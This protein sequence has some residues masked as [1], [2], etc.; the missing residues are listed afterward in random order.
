MTA[1]YWPQ[2]RWPAVLRSP[3]SI[4]LYVIIV[5]TSVTQLIIGPEAAH[6]VTEHVSTNLANLLAFRWP[7]LVAS[8][9]WLEGP[10]FVPQLAVWFVL[11]VL[12]LVPAEQ[13]LGTRRWLLAFL[14]AHIGATIVTAF[15]LW[16]AVELGHQPYAAHHAIDVGLSYGFLGVLALQVYRLPFGW[17]WVA[18]GA[19]LAPLF[20]ILRIDRQFTDAGHVM[21]VLIGLSMYPIAK[22]ARDEPHAA[23]VGAAS[24]ATRPARAPDRVVSPF[25][26]D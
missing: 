15:R 24:S 19:L 18:A 26:E 22:A 7:V 23:E 3:A 20:V 12:V 5:A 16:I 6:R 8:A 13:W 14:L 2:L 11:F 4:A 17:R 1:R 25:R 21:A 10:G 9:F